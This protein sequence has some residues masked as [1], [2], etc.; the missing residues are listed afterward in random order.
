MQQNKQEPKGVTAAAMQ[1]SK[2]PRPTTKAAARSAKSRADG[3]RRDYPDIKGVP[4]KVSKSQRAKYVADYIAKHGDPK[5][6]PVEP[7]A[8]N[9]MPARRSKRLAASP[10]KAT[11]TPTDGASNKNPITID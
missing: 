10:S 5:K 1:K 2:P 3:L 4:A 7:S 11:A 8:K 9:K 6:K